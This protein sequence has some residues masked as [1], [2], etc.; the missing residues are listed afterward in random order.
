MFA[1]F[2][3]FMSLTTQG[4]VNV[5]NA[6]LFPS[7]EACEEQLPQTQAYLQGRY[8][9]DTEWKYFNTWCVCR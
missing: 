8:S 9:K 6:M 7:K 4:N 3:I 2:S 5:S 1:M